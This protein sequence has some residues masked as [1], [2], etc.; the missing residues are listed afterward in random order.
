MPAKRKKTSPSGAHRSA[1]VEP[2]GD[3]PAPGKGEK[4][5]SATHERTALAA[6]SRAGMANEVADSR[7]GASSVP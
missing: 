4:S 3:A 1:A 7:N 2:E 6:S 5:E